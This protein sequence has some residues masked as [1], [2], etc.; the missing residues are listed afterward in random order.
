LLQAMVGF[1]VVG[2]DANFG[3]GRRI[4]DL[5]VVNPLMG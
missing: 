1:E 3:H 4:A 5:D 2:T